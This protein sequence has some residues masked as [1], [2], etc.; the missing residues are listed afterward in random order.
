MTVDIEEDYYCFD[1]KL[2]CAKRNRTCLARR[3][4]SKQRTNCWRRENQKTNGRDV[5]YFFRYRLLRKKKD[6]DDY[7]RQRQV[8][9][10]R[11]SKA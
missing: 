6:F 8:A 7:N 1:E 3:I 10:A 9:A 2:Q 5:G 4:D 11:K